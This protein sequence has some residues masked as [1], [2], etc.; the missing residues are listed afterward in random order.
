ML[1]PNSVHT[2]KGYGKSS[3]KKIQSGNV[4]ALLAGFSVS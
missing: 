3:H 4:L 2:D 1:L